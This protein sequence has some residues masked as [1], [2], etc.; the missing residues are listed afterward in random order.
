PTTE[1]VGIVGHGEREGSWAP[2]ELGCLLVKEAR[3]SHVAVGEA[4][5]S[6]PHQGHGPLATFRTDVRW[7]GNQWQSGRCSQLRAVRRCQ[8]RHIRSSLCISDL[9]CSWCDR[10]GGGDEERR[11]DLTENPA[12]DCDQRY[13]DVAH[14]RGARRGGN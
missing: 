4:L 14:P 13:G 8:C 6:P 9:R 2:V 11:L 7:R 1:L 5:V 3:R 12:V 10:G